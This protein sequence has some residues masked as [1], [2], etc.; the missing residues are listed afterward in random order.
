MDQPD[1]CGARLLPTYIQ[2]QE[3]PT[4]VDN[5]TLQL[6]AGSAYWEHQ[7]AST[8]EKETILLT[9]NGK[10]TALVHGWEWGDIRDG[11]DA[12]FNATIKRGPCQHPI[13]PNT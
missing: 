6:A 11:P 13:L 8:G 4:V 1:T 10:R 5:I 2:L 12:R 7:D 3:Y 9:V